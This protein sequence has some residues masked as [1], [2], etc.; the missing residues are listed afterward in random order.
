MTDNDINTQVGETSQLDPMTLILQMRKKMEI[1]ITK[2]TLSL[3]VRGITYYG[4]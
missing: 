4:W 1:P 2:W 3:S